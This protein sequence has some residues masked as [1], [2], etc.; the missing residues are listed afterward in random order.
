MAQINTTDSED[1]IIVKLR[2]ER[3]LKIRTIEGV[4][5]HRSANN[6]KDIHEF[7]LL[8]A[9]AWTDYQFRYNIPLALQVPV[10]YVSA[11]EHTEPESGGGDTVILFKL[12][13]R[14]RANMSPDGER[15]PQDVMF[16][17]E[18]Q[19]PDDPTNLIH[20]YS[21]RR[22]NMVEFTVLSRHSKDANRIA[23]SFEEFMHAYK[24]YF[25]DMGINQLFFESRDE[26]K[27]FMVGPTEYQLRS[28]KF[29]V[30][31]EMLFRREF[32]KLDDITILY[33]TGSKLKTTVINSETGL[34]EQ[35][36]DRGSIS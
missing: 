27:S 9:E 33:D 8:V 10:K 24:W 6:N 7:L 21:M 4:P 25:K 16:M 26:D 20:I 35:E 2:S 18:K 23:M 29:N 32:R 28:L 12:L 15:R 30:R 19:D 31:T 11:K 22:D 1:T 13:S 34:K 17:E 3:G 14:K 36:I 5:K